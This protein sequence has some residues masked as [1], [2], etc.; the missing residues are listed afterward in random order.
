[1]IVKIL[2]AG[3]DGVGIDVED[4]RVGD[5]RPRRIGAEILDVGDAEADWLGLHS[6]VESP[7]LRIDLPGVVIQKSAHVLPVGRLQMRQIDQEVG[8]LHTHRLTFGIQSGARVH[9]NK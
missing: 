8:P 1:M 4:A 5:G 3:S 7:A 6:P 9:S 2:P